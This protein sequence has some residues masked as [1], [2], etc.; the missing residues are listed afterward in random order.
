MFCN[1]GRS[2]SAQV[3]HVIQELLGAMLA[4]IKVLERHC[5]MVSQLLG[6]V[7]LLYIVLVQLNDL[8]KSSALLVV[9]QCI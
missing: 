4:V 2:R 8:S 5:L 3:S 9:K 6:S 1:F 7:L